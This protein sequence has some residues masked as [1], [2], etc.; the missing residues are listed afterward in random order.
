MRKIKTAIIGYGRSG[1]NIHTHTLKQLPELFEIAFYVDGDS[2]R[3]DMIR[4]E[5]NKPV[6][7]DYKALFAHND[8]D[9]VINASFS[10]DHVPLSIDLMKHGFNVLC[11]KPAARDADEFRTVLDAAKKFDKKYYTF[12]QY[13]FSPSFLKI[14]EI[15]ASG[16][17]GRI[18][19][20]KLRHERLARRWDWQTVHDNSAG[21]LLNN[22]PHN[23]DMALILMGFPENVEVFAVMDRAN[24]AGNAEDFAKLILRAPGAPMIDIEHTASNA[25]PTQ[26]YHV[27]GTN[28]TLKGSV[29]SLN[30]KYFKPEEAGPLKLDPRPLRN[31]KGEPVYCSEKL[32]FYEDSWTLD[33]GTEKPGAFD[34]N[35]QGL[36]YYRALYN[37]FINDQEFDVKNEQVLLQMKIMGAA[38]AQ[39]KGLFVQ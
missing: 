33:A 22:G 21:V 36:S 17:L 34:E 24:Y 13:R 18:I 19:A 29:S 7:P 6:Y 12:Q 14:K 11:E 4:R 30:W 23:V 5:M 20:V 31:E 1:R 28:G 38:F 8:I 26:L 9:L 39:N 27:Q 16:V 25:Y 37:S 32:N 15:I 10:Y 3:Q 2:E 35:I